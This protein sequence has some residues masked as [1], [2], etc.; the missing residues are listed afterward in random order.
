MND[1]KS[2]R[3]GVAHRCG[4]EALEGRALL[5]APTVI[6]VM[7][8]YDSAAKTALGVNDSQILKLIRQSI[9][10]ANQ[11]HYNT[12]DN[13]VLRLVDSEPIAFTSSGNFQTD[14]DALA[15]LPSVKTLRD[16]P[17]PFGEGK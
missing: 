14:L 17:K 15:D 8:L 5:A 6:D 7:V 12:Q 11:A 9:D 3:S 13:I 10:T 1:R 16:N 2:V 4:V